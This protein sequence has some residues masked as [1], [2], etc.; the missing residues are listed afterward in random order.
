MWWRRLPS[1]LLWCITASLIVLSLLMLSALTFQG[2]RG[3][4]LVEHRTWRDVLEAVSASRSARAPAEQGSASFHAGVVSSWTVSRGEALPPDLPPYLAKLAPGYYSSEGAQGIDAGDKQFHALIEDVAGTRIITSVDITEIEQQQNSDSRLSLAW[5]ALF[6]AVIGFVIW[7]LHTNL[8]RPVRDLA[9][10]MLELDPADTGQRLPV[11]YR[12]HEIQV[13]ARATNAHL[14][15]VELLIHNERALLDQASHEFRT[16]VAIISGAVDV[17]RSHK[18]PDHSRLVVDRIGSTAQGLSE[19]MQSL[20]SLARERRS[21]APEEDVIELHRLLPEILRDHQHLV[22]GRPVR[23]EM[24]WIERTTLL[25]PE[26]MARIALSNIVRNAAEH[27][28]VG[29]IVISVRDNVVSVVD[30]GSGLDP[31]QAAHHYLQSLK[32]GATARGHGIGL[33]LVRRICDRLGWRLSITSA[34]RQGTGVYLDVTSSLVPDAE[35]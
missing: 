7:L 30:T 12:Q 2:F 5:A 20:L 4:E 6:M 10:R 1:S 14:E 26:A 13:I 32:S 33:F 11:D 25:A 24:G 8:V 28:E 17:L 18:L 23:F 16:P 29:T 21:T 19:I 31:T 22:E 15:R 35:D 34:S 9:D 3:Q 27:T